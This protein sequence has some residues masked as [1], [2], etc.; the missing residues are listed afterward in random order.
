MKFINNALLRDNQGATA[1]EYAMILAIVGAAI[2]VAALGLGNTVATS[3]NTSASKMQNC[4]GG[5]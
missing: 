2:A 3:M 5:C 1:A 4:G